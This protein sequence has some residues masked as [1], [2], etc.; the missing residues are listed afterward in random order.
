MEKYLTRLD[1]PQVPPYEPAAMAQGLTAQLAQ[2]L[3]PL[4]NKWLPIM[5]RMWQDRARYDEAVYR[6]ARERRQAPRPESA[7]A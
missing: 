2:F 1:A 4:A 5:F 6:T 3:F 7:A